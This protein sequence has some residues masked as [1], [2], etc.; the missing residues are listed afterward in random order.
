MRR[1]I[2][3]LLFL[4]GCTVPFIRPADLKTI[5]ETWMNE[6]FTVKSE[7]RTSDLI[8][9]TGRDEVLFGKGARVRVWVEAGSD[10]VKVKAYPEADNREQARGKLIIYIFKSDLQEGQQVGDL[11]RQKLLAMLDPVKR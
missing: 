10:W 4:T 11:L 7:I 2:L 8:G 3:S 1:L 9:K 5:N 6:V